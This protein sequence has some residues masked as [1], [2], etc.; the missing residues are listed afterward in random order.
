MES[1]KEEKVEISVVTRMPEQVKWDHFLALAF[2]HV[3]SEKLKFG[4]NRSGVGKGKGKMKILLSPPVA[5]SSL[6]NEHTLGIMFIWVSNANSVDSYFSVSNLT[7]TF[8]LFL[9]FL[10]SFQG[11]PS[12]QF[13]YL[14]SG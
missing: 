8:P 11:I 7:T 4:L 2:S 1:E 12:F 9:D 5:L 13:S 3:D 10:L 6:R 14:R